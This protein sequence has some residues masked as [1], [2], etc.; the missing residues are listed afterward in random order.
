MSKP[1]T[2]DGNPETTKSIED[3]ITLGTIDEMTYSKFSIVAET[4]GNKDTASVQ[5]PENN[6][7]YDYMKELKTDCQEIVLTDEDI[8]KYRYNPKKLAYD[9]YGH[10]ELYFVILAINGMCS[11]KDFNKRKIKLLYKNQVQ[12]LLNE[13]Y[14]A[15]SDY[16]SKNRAK[17]KN[18]ENNSI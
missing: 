6:I 10:S 16:I 15:E 11:F 18:T 17:L 5:F 8:I 9:I 3:F 14:N 12:S 2:T 7:I 1:M 13:I 4:I